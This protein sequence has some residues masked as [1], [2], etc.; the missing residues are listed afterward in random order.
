[1]RT[2]YRQLNGYDRQKEMFTTGS[3]NTPKYGNTNDVDNRL[4]NCRS[5]FGPEF[6]ALAQWVDIYQN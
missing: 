3:A 2:V 1:M 4:M 6:F 5:Q